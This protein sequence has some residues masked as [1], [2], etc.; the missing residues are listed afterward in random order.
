MLVNKKI[1]SANL[2]VKNDKKIVPCNDK[3]C[4]THG[5]LRVRKNSYEGIVVKIFRVEKR[6]VLLKNKIILVKKYK[7][8][9]KKTS[10]VHCHVP[11][12]LE[13]HIKIGQKVKYKSCRPISFIKKHIIWN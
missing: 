4:H 2:N 5:F 9:L 10:K 1:E 7:K 13:K 8:Y 11:S 6:C 3:H 12:C